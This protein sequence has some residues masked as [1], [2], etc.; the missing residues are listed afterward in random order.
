MVFLYGGNLGVAQD[1]AGIL[2]LADALRGE[3]RAF[4]LLVGDGSEAAAL[5]AEAA[6]R[7]L[8]NVRFLPPVDHATYL[9]MVTEFDVGLITLNRD[10]KT[11]NFPSKMHDFMYCGKPILAAVNP[12][13][14]LRELLEEEEAGLV[15]WAGEDEELRA[16]ALRLLAD[17]DLRRRLGRNGGRLLREVFSPAQAARQILAHASPSAAG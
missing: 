16:A 9:G 2:R 5:E 1:V 7:G 15:S 4:F 12:G 3:P 13:N 17:G 14:D 6:R 8:D 10:L 11:H